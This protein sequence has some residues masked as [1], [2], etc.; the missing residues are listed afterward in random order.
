MPPE[1]LYLLN[2]ETL[3]LTY[4]ALRNAC[5]NTVY[6]FELFSALIVNLI[7][8]QGIL[9]QRIQMSFEKLAT[10]KPRILA[11]LA[12]CSSSKQQCRALDCI[13]LAIKNNDCSLSNW[14]QAS[15]LQQQIVTSLVRRVLV[16]CPFRGILPHRMIYTRGR[17]E[18]IN[19]ALAVRAA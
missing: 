1:R 10:I 13:P 19:K 11:G 16:T 8:V 18:I 15:L 6:L 3:A 12:K 14:W 4:L 5:F 17:V 9:L 7:L 2:K